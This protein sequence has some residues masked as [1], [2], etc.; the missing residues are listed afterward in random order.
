MFLAEVCVCIGVCTEDRGPCQ[1]FS[2]VFF[3]FIYF[4]Q[5]GSLSD[6]RAHTDFSDLVR[7][8]Q[9]PM[10]SASLV[11]KSNSHCHNTFWF[12]VC[13]SVDQTGTH[14]YRK[15]F[16]DETVPPYFL[17][18]LIFFYVG[19]IP[20]PNYLYVRLCSCQ[21][22]FGAH[23]EMFYIIFNSETQMASIKAKKLSVSNQLTQDRH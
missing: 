8:H 19:I 3:H 11:L 12:L 15:K 7:E 4:I 13:E 20:L 16:T 5:T 23:V 6:P 22:Q 21:S 17:G 14:D 2:S 18:F 1:M 10:V 9:A